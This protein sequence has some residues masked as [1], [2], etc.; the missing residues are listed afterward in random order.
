MQIHNDIQLPPSLCTFARFPITKLM[1]AT[2][3]KKLPDT[4]ER[5]HVWKFQF[6]KLTQ[7]QTKRQGNPSTS[8]KNCCKEQDLL[9]AK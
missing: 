4:L 8:R 5:T 2:N 3:K 9:L 1:D 6:T 7:D